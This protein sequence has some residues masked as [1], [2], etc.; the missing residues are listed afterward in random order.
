[1]RNNVD[2]SHLGDPSLTTHYLPSHGTQTNYGSTGFGMKTLKKEG[3]MSSTKFKGTFGFPSQLQ[4]SRQHLLNFNLQL[5]IE[6]N[7]D[8]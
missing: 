4:Q 1:M 2:L 5:I 7:R 3:T 6:S 8:T